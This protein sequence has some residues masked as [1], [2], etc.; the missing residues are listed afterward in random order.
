MKEWNWQ[1]N[2]KCTFFSA[3]FRQARIFQN[4]NFV[5]FSMIWKN[6]ARPKITSVFK[7][8][9]LH[10]EDFFFFLA[11]IRR[12]HV[13]LLFFRQVL[14]IIKHFYFVFSFFNSIVQS[15]ILERFLR[16]LMHIILDISICL[17]F[18]APAGSKLGAH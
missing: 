14:F 9:F 13:I 1:K 12:I 8:S 7:I 18:Y 2:G 5:N 4:I 6:F 11:K 17:L 16:L 3:K 15:I 10:T